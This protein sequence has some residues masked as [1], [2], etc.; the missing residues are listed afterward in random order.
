MALLDV[1]LELTL[2]VATM[3]VAAT[4]AIVGPRRIVAAIRDF[5]WRLEA[6]LLPLAVLAAVLLLRWSTQ[7]VVQRLERR[8]LEN[9]ITP[10]LSAFDQAMLEPV[11]VLQSF[12][13]EALTSFFVFI[14]IYGYAFLLIFPFIAYFAL[15]EMDDLS[16]LILSFTANY[17]IGLLFYTLFIAYGPRNLSPEL[18]E[19][20]LYTAFPQ[21]GALTH[22]IN[23]NTNVFPSLH[24][25]LSMTVFFLAWVT[26]EKY[27][28]WVP[29]AG[30]LAISVALSTMYLGIHWFSDVVAGTVLALVSVYIGVNYTV[31]EIVDGIRTFVASRFQSPK[32][33][34]E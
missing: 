22:E 11:I 8:V 14:Y 4:L 3:L 13:T 24:T 2:I 25:S 9:N 33:D 20:L 27:P 7:D 34:G 5:R 26:R 21:S 19:G 29:V 6:C 12:Q 30:F 15:E 1:L 17:A 10:Q 28:S 32:A 23:Q 18:F 16:T 31:E